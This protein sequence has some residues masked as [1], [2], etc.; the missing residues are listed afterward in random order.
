MRAV[1]DRFLYALAGGAPTTSRVRPVNPTARDGSGYMAPSGPALPVLAGDVVLDGTADLR[2][3]TEGLVVA[4]Y[5]PDSGQDRPTT[6]AGWF[7]TGLPGT[8]PAATTRPGQPV[9]PIDHKAP[10]TPHGKLLLLESGVEF[11]NGDV[12]YC[13]L[14]YVRVDSMDQEDEPH[15][16]IT[17]ETSDLHAFLQD[18]GTVYE[19][20]FTPATTMQAIFETLCITSGWRGMP[21]GFQTTDLDLDAEFAAM[22]LG[23]TRTTDGDRFAFM[24]TLVGER[25]RIWYWDGRGK[26]VVKKPPAAG[27]TTVHLDVGGPNDKATPLVRSGRRLTR[28]G[29]ANVIVADQSG[30]TNTPAIRSVVYDGDSGAGFS[31]ATYVFS[32]GFVVERVGSPLI[33]SDAAGRAFARTR[34]NR[35]RAIPDQRRVLHAVNGAVEPFDLQRVWPRG[36]V[37]PLGYTYRQVETT[38]IPLVPGRDQLTEYVEVR[39]E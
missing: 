12:E 24:R 25:D 4:A 38:R 37:D 10:L 31:S 33:T 2:M 13:R 6:S 11:G 14:G 3:R 15:G 35:R 7:P 9:W 5:W 16:P 34:L 19:H 20:S 28:E 22:T 29:V 18:A 17:L 27:G 26:L 32:Y 30:V 23:A 1:S 8:S 39:A 36:S 21:S